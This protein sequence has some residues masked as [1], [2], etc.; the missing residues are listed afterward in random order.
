MARRKANG[1]RLRRPTTAGVRI[2]GARKLRATGLSFAKIGQRM[3]INRPDRTGGGRV[4]NQKLRIGATVLTIMGQPVALAPHESTSRHPHCKTE[5]RLRRFANGE[6]GH[7]S[8]ESE[9]VATGHCWCDEWRQDAFCRLP[10][11]PLEGQWNRNPRQSRRIRRRNTPPLFQTQTRASA[12][13]PRPR[14]NKD[15]VAMGASPP[16]SN[17]NRRVPQS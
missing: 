17:V 8:T 13:N 16:V 10:R 15:T 9:P 6:I 5:N 4:L 11:P 1:K 7:R 12:E 14:Q 2:E 3:G